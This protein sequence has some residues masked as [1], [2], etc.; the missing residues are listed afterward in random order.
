M[1]CSNSNMG[2][3]HNNSDHL[4]QTVCCT[5]TT[6]VQKGAPETMPSTTGTRGTVPVYPGWRAAN[7][8][9]PSTRL[10]GLGLS[11]V[12][13]GNLPRASEPGTGPSSPGGHASKLCHHAALEHMD[14][15]WRKGSAP[16]LGH[17]KVPYR[18]VRCVR[19][20]AE[21]RQLHMASLEG[22]GVCHLNRQVK[23]YSWHALLHA[24][25]EI[26]AMAIIQCR[27]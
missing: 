6:C 15:V 14:W 4:Q 17:G 2:W 1:M 18:C 12:S 5:R 24:P 9:L 8:Q 20:S 25:P 11:W 23:T 13:R 27:S 26:K 21:A 7:H 10:S 22:G 3:Q 16:G 19:P